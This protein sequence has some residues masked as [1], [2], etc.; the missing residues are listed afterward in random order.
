MFSEAFSAAQAEIADPRASSGPPRDLDRLAERPLNIELARFFWLAEFER[1]GELDHAIAWKAVERKQA[2]FWGRVQ[3]IAPLYVTSICSEHCLYCNF[4]GPNKGVDVDRY[5]LSHDEIAQE[6]SFLIKQKGIRCIELV[7]ASDP[8]MRA[9]VICRHVELTG[10]LLARSGG[11]AVGVNAEPF[12]GAD[13]RRLR[14]AGVAFVA[15]WQETYDRELYGRLHPCGRKSDFE[16]RLNSYERMIDAGI[17][18]IG[19]GVLTGLAD[20]RSDCWRSDWTMLMQH[21]AYLDRRYGVTPSIL[22]I[23]RLKPA[24]G[25]VFEPDVEPPADQEF[26]ACVALHN[27]FSPYTQPF[28]STREHWDLCVELS[29]GGGCLFTFSCSTTPGGYSLGRGGRQFDTRSF[30]AP[31]A[32]EALRRAGLNPDFGTETHAFAAALS[33]SHGVSG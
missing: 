24:K 14:D 20:W 4:R 10:R 21:E 23:P 25:A 5:R 6:A 7:Y 26:R 29:R 28:I 8:R 22:G 33:E 13:Y 9:D 3:P 1:G 12:S 2:I 16:W 30:D 15:L 27:I 32:A 17:D 19:L 18:H 31:A 11:G